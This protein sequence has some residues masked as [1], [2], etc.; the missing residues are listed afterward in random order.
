[1]GI[2]TGI[3]GFQTL[4]NLEAKIVEQTIQTGT[5]TRGLPPKRGLTILAA[6]LAAA[7]ILAAIWFFWPAQPITLHGVVLKQD[8]DPR[9]QLPIAGVAISAANANG[10]V[11]ASVTS[12][13]SAVFT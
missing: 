5:P 7:G 9:K 3:R 10:S 2:C 1:M 8:A 6:A 12:D 13:S 4:W 11:V